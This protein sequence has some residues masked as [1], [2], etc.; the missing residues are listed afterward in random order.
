MTLSANGMV[1]ATLSDRRTGRMMMMI[2]AGV[3][4]LAR[5]ALHPRWQRL[6]SGPKIVANRG[7]VHWICKN[8]RKPLDD[9]VVVSCDRVLEPM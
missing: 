1:L 5:D 9:S 6:Q 4:K 3:Q 2:I 8:K 7:A